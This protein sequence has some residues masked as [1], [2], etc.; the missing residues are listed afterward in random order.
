MKI[1]IIKKGEY[2]IWS[3]RMR[4]YICHTD[5]NLWDIIV[6]GDLH[7]EA[8]PAG[9]QSGPLAPKTA[10]QITA[11]R[12]QERVKSILLL[13]IPDEYLLKFHNVLDAKSLWA[14]I[15]SSLDKA[16]DR[17][18][19]LISQ[20][21]V[22]ATPVSKEDINQKFLRSLP[23]SWSQIAL[24]MRN[25][26]ICPYLYLMNLYN[27]LRVYED[28]MKRSSSS[29]SNSKECKIRKEPWEEKVI[30]VLMAEGNDYNKWNHLQSN[31]L[32]QDGLG[33]A[34]TGKHDFD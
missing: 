4:Q 16:Y 31:W 2:D 34:V 30:L 22:H 7:E 33:K 25:K 15:K 12:N 14:A 26:P 6:D 18:Q 21:E 27:N 23:P 3:M 20:L 19:K 11:K 24:I 32:A 29:I 1:P 28:E 5:H 9:E 13:A 17:F 10:K 8:A